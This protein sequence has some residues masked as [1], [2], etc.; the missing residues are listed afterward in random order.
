M[1]APM[2]FAVTLASRRWWIALV[3]SAVLIALVEIAQAML[4]TGLCEGGDASRNFAGALAGTAVAWL[5][6]R[7]ARRSGASVRA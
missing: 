3:V 1:Y 7:F 4:G 5:G 6:L 2:A